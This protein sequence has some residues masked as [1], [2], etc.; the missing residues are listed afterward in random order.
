MMILRASDRGC[1]RAS[2]GRDRCPATVTAAA[3]QPASLKWPPGRRGKVTRGQSRWPRPD[4][5]PRT[6]QRPV[7]LQ[8][9]ALA[10]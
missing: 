1:V 3:E 4:A 9:R 6:D 10:P 7:A 5:G 2:E 8:G